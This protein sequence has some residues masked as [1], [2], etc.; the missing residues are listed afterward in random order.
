M[1]PEAH[2]LT[3]DQQRIWRSWLAGV[4]QI[5]AFL[6]ADLH[7]HA[8]DLS[9]YE[10]LVSLS[11]SPDR[12][13]RMSDL[14]DTVHQSR[15]RLTHTIAR[16]ERRR[17][18]DRCAAECDGRGVYAILTDKGSE[19]LDSVA[20]SHVNAVREIF[21]DRCDPNDFQALGRI[22]SAVLESER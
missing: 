15:S 20:P 9:E 22:M 2:W 11:E 12:R 19:V 13:M 18:V 8:L 6:E 4:A 17:L 7:R 5:N 10:I 21:V 14:A 16:L 3:D 1:N